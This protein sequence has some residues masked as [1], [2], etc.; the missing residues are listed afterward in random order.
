MLFPAKIRFS[1]PKNNTVCVYVGANVSCNRRKIIKFKL[2]SGENG[3][4]LSL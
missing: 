2:L 1:S 3:K 4:L